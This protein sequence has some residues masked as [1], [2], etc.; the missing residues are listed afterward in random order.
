MFFFFFPVL[1]C[2]V[3][4]WKV[5]FL[6]F[7]YRYLLY[8]YIPSL[9]LLFCTHIHAHTHTFMYVCLYDDVHVYKHSK[10]WKIQP[11]KSICLVV[12]VSMICYILCITWFREQM[13]I[14][15]KLSW[16]KEIQ[17]KLRWAFFW[18]KK[19]KIVSLSFHFKL[20]SAHLKSYVML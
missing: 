6:S 9:V 8:W 17:R 2:Q 13:K 7:S 20:S 11:S 15:K 3:L 5:M 18:K 14:G 4:I 10:I 16:R 12:H 19:K 1:N